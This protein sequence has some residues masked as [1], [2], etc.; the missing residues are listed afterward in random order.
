MLNN[1]DFVAIDVGL[2][3]IA[4]LANLLLVG[5]FLS[6]PAGRGRLEFVLG[7]T[8]VALALPLTGAVLLNALAG[9]AWWTIALPIPLI[10]FCGAELILDYL[11]KLD[12]RHSD[13][14]RP[15]LLLYYV[16]L[17]AMMGYAFGVGKV[18]GLITLSTYA[19]NL[20]A[21]WYSYSQV[22]HGHRGQQPATHG[23]TADDQVGA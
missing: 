14:L 22:G 7:L 4:N 6:R 19:L 9:R 23:R 20:G 21:T 8:F 18:A 5:I 17:V 11:L 3:V 12:F 1:L 16:S 15:Y 10:Q 2:A 13:L